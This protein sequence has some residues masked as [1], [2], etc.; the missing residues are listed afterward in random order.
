MFNIFF[1]CQQGQSY[2]NFILSRSAIRSQGY[3]LLSFLCNNTLVRLFPWQGFRYVSLTT[4]LMKYDICVCFWTRQKCS[5]G[6]DTSSGVARGSKG[7]ESPLDSKTFTKY[8]EKEG[9]NQEKS[10]KR[11]KNQEKEEKFGKV[12]SLCLSWQI[13]LATLLNTSRLLDRSY[14]QEFIII[15][16]FSAYPIIH[17]DQRPV[18][19]YFDL[20]CHLSKPKSVK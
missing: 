18:Y 16:L 1:L 12:L 10:G 14:W 13:G 4:G 19:R 20:G 3:G 17:F 8:R 7:A 11:G 9:E 6:K 2:L 15:D 5:Q